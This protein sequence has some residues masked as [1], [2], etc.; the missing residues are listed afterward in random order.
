M[1]SLNPDEAKLAPE[2]SDMVS[3]KPGAIRAERERKPMTASRLLR[4]I[5]QIGA[6]GILLWV[7]AV[8][9]L[10]LSYALIPP[11]STLMLGRWLTLQ[12]VTRDFVSLKEISPHLSLAVMT[13]EDSL[14]CQHSGVDWQ[15]IREVVEAADEDGPA[16]GASTIPMQ[17]AKNLFLWPGRSYVRK[18]LELPVALY[19]D[20]IWPKTKMMENYLNIAEWGDGI[21]GA[22]AAARAYFRKSVKDLTRREAA[23][24]ATALPN[25]LVRNPA[26]PS[27]SHA[28]RAATILARMESAAP[29]A[30]CLKD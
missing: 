9:W 25:P 10:G 8:F 13:S 16:R 20:L 17:T 19:L 24:L 21:F 14:F 30:G 7:A 12:P 15:A 5:V 23:L 29:Y 11:V 1:F 26:R 2:E 22:E 4:R 18:G 6:W 27:R 3:L 28:A